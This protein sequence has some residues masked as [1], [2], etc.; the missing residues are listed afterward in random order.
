MTDRELMETARDFAHKEIEILGEGW[1]PQ[2]EP[3]D[4]GIE[5]KCV[6]APWKKD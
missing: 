4:G 3:K 6:P 5:V 1:I 2:M